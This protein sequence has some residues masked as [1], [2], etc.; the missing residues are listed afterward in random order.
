M[1][2]GFTIKQIKN[3]S[4]N[5]GKFWELHPSARS[6][7]AFRDLHTKDKSPYKITSSKKA[8]FCILYIHPESDFYYLEHEDKLFDLAPDLFP[9]S[10]TNHQKMYETL[11]PV[12]DKA[13]DACLSDNHKHLLV[14]KKKAQ[15]RRKVY[16][17][18]VYT[19]INAKQL[20][21]MLK[22]EKHIMGAIQECEDII[23]QASKEGAIRGDGE[24]SLVESGGLFS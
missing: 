9:P 6:M 15:E 22:S 2:I 12:M 7:G 13:R 8:W 11:E 17:D 24:L 20:D 1:G 4:N 23:K 10:V 21:D 18:N 14:L 3:W 19:L 16:E 5:L